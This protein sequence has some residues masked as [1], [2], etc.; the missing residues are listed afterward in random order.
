[1]PE[2]CV[3]TLKNPLGATWDKILQNVDFVN[4]NFDKAKV[5]LCSTRPTKGNTAY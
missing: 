3:E 5:S 2:N 4:Q 1:M